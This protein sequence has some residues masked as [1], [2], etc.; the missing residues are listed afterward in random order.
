V[1]QEGGKVKDWL[2]ENKAAAALAAITVVAFAIL[3][4]LQGCDVRS[5]LVVKAPSDML[6]AI[7]VDEPLTLDEVEATWEDW[8]AWVESRTR[9]YQRAVADA[10]DRAARIEA[11]IDLGLAAANEGAAQLP[12]GAFLVGGL[13]L[14]T[15][16]FLKR[17]GTD[18]M[19]AKEKEA[20]YNAGLEE[21]RKIVLSAIKGDEPNQP[22]A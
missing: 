19:T 3:G 4:A 9:Q 15:G 10:E 20:S 13:S 17:P 16:I 22:S 21:G 14:L 1:P 5:R 12:G 6:A 2:N 8:S 18:K 11:I 7:D